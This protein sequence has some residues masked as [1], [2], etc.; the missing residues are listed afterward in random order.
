MGRWKMLDNLRRSLLAPAAMALL[1]AAWAEPQAQPMLWLLVVLGP[2]LWPALMNAVELLVRTPTARSRRMHLRR[3]LFDFGGELERAAVSL[4]LLAQNAWLAID[5]IARAVYRTLRHTQHMLEWVTAAQ[6]KAGRSSLLSSFVWPMKSASI[7]VVSTVA[8]LLVMNP[9]AV[10]RIAPL[11]VLWW[12]SPV[13]ARYLSR[14][15]V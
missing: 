2:A 3:L 11:L 8:V 12:L 1:M 7:V 10:T 5:A 15:A 14:A 9:P 13:V 6:S 4:A